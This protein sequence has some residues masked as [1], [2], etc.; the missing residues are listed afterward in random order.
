M[1]LGDWGAVACSDDGRNVLDASVYGPVY[2]SHN[3]GLS[4]T[5]VGALYGMMDFTFLPNGRKIF[6][7]GGGGLYESNDGGSTWSK[8]PMSGIE[9]ETLYYGWRSV[10]ASANGSVLAVLSATWIG[11]LAVSTN[12]GVSWE[13]TGAGF[14]TVDVS[15]DG[16]TMVGVASG[17]GGPRSVYISRDSGKTWN[18]TSSPETFWNDVK[19]STDGRTIVALKGFFDVFYPDTDKADMIYV[20]TD[21]GVTWEPRFPPIGIWNEIICPANAKTMVLVPDGFIFRSPPCVSYDGGKSWHTKNDPF[22]GLI[23]VACSANGEIMYASSLWSGT[24]IYLSK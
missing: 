15:A 19:I 8:N 21:F 22:N 24:Y 2:L 12:S 3:Y 5:R 16:K 17:S 23:G 11:F 1:P 13:L 4:W 10:H 18:P 14:W 6:A 7:A 20:S 9:G